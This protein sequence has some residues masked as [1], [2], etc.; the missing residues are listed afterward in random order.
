MKLRGNPEV[1]IIPK[2]SFS[3]D[4][5]F[6]EAYCTQKHIS[7]LSN[8]VNSTHFLTKVWGILCSNCF[9]QS[10][11]VNRRFFQIHRVSPMYKY[12]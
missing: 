1:K 7:F 10:L 2:N 5:D 12:T 9:L 6:S 8:D 3:F 4:L 11:P